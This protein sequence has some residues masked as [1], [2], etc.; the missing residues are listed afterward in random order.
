MTLSSAAV[1]AVLEKALDFRLQRQTLIASNLANAQTPSYRSKDISFEDKL[2]EA[3][4]RDGLSLKRTHQ[5]HIDLQPG[6]SALHPDLVV[7]DQPA[8]GNDLN[9]V[10][11]EKE[12]LKMSSNS[13]LYNVL[14]TVMNRK[15]TGLK[16]A[17]Q[18]GGK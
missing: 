10:D 14:T 11:M 17:I 18:E 3:V 12:L 9:S 2:R 8:I 16:T 6:L 5:A 15:L 7:P 13:L 1:M 4:H